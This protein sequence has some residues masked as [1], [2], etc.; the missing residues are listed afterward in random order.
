MKKVAV[1]GPAGTNGHEAACR[2]FDGITIDDI[3]FCS[4]NE[5]IFEMVLSGESEQGVVPIRNSSTGLIDD[6]KRFWI[7][8]SSA[9]AGIYPVM[10][11]SLP[12]RHC[13]L[14]HPASSDVERIEKVLSHPEALKQCDL[15]I[16]RKKIG[17]TVAALSTADASRIVSDDGGQNSLAAIASKFTASVYGLKV[18]EEDFQDNA[19][20]ATRFHLVS[21]WKTM[22]TSGCKTAVIFWL[23]HEPSALVSAL[24]IISGAGRNIHMIEPIFSGNNDNVAFYV[25]FDGHRLEPVTLSILTILDHLANRLVVLGSYSEL[26]YL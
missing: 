25:E 18:L 6:A 8:E 2:F 5:D 4:R 17:E 24:N 23:K 26:L 20:N 14:V 1:L 16:K 12:I 11:L 7:K 10:E 9:S 15:A 19:G 22:P 21:T 13:L 3:L